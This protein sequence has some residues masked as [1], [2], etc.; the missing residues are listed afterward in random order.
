MVLAEDE[1]SLDLAFSLFFWFLLLMASTLLFFFGVID[2]LKQ[3]VEILG[4]FTELMKVL[5]TLLVLRS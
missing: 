2:I 3:K 4:K 1:S 5:P